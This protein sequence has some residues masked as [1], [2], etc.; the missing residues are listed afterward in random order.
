MRG[1][2]S[3]FCLCS[4]CLWPALGYGAFEDLES[5]VR[6]QGLANAYTAVAEGASAIHY[7]PA[8]LAHADSLEVS[9]FYK[10]LFSIV[11]NVTLD[12]V[13]PTK[14][15]TFGASFQSVS[16]KGDYTEY[17]GVPEKPK[18]VEAD[19]T[20]EED[21]A[22]TLSHGFGLTSDL[23]FGYNIVVYSL[24]QARFGTG[25]AVGT[26]VGF[27]A[28]LYRRWQLGLFAHNINQPKVGEEVSHGLPRLIS[29]GVAYTPFSGVTTTLDFSKEVGWPTR[30]AVGQEFPLVQDLLL[31]RAGVQSEPFRWSAGF[32]ARWQQAILD[33]AY[34]SHEVLPST[35]QVGLAFRF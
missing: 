18:I 1:L 7:N 19:A 21:R 14:W 9:A 11:H 25:W 29:A 24:K 33:Y 8:G 2:L 13:Y 6:A 22:I 26:D 4:V 30:L 31:V 15:G 5:G 10:K 35:H 3:L 12:A 28:K 34:A 17:S 20:L 16:V 32:G 27:L 23:S